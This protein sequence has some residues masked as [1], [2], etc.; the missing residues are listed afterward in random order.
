MI[1]QIKGETVYSDPKLKYKSNKFIKCTKFKIISNYFLINIIACKFKITLYWYRM[2][3]RTFS[4][5]NPM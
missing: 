3:I 4:N 1:G 2:A 5:W